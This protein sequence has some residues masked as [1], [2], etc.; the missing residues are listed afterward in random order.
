M[1]AR[2]AASVDRLGEFRKAV[3]PYS[4]TA[5]VKDFD[6]KFGELVRSASV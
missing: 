6:I 2:L 1:T 3:Q 4:S 5:Q